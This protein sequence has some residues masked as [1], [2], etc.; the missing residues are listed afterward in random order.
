MTAILRAKT[1]DTASEFLDSLIEYW[2][3]V[4]G[5]AQRQ[6]HSGQKEG[7]PV[8]LEDARLVVFQTLLVMYEVH[9]AASRQ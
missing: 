9:R 3:T 4:S 7:R 5:L 8:D 2:R 6:E 1:G